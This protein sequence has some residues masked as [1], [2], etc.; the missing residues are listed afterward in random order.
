[1]SLEVFIGPGGSLAPIPLS[2]SSVAVSSFISA[3]E[4]SGNHSLTSLQETLTVHVDSSRGPS[5]AFVGTSLGI[6]QE[7][8]DSK[9]LTR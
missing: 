5:R 9:L 4:F 6:D 7:G 8:K 1:M 2:G 3:A